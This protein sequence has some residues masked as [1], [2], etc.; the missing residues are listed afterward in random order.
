[1][2]VFRGKEQAYSGMYG[3]W[4]DSFMKMNDFK[5]ELLRQNPGSVVEVD[6]ETKGNKKLFLRFFISLIACSK[7]FLDGCRPCISLDACHL[8]GKF[9][10][11][12]VAATSVDYNSSIFHVAYGVLESENKTSW[13]WFLELLK[14]AIGMPNGLVISSDMQKVA[15]I[16]FTRDVNLDNHVDSYFTIEKFK[17]A[18]ALEVAPMP[19]KD[20]WVHIDTEEKI[21]PPAIKRPS[22]I[23]RKNRIKPNDES[24]KR[25][26]CPR[27][28]EYGHREKTCKNPASQDS[29]QHQASTSKMGRRKSTKD[30]ENN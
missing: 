6:F 13:L 8:K 1:M 27:C 10:G 5:E 7:G 17:L 26:K 11:V 19:A 30:R 22:G 15:F 21:C 12:V 20:Q 14:K 23:L 16:T 9:N 4:E 18:Y 24:K 2:K 28:G 29:I 25:H 3:K